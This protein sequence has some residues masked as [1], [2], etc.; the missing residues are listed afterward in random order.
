[1]ASLQVLLDIKAITPASFDR[2]VQQLQAERLDIPNRPSAATELAGRSTSRSTTLRSA[3]SSS[4]TQPARS[5]PPPPPR[6]APGA[7]QVVA[8]ADFKGETGDDLSFREGDVIDVLEDG[9]SL[10]TY[11]NSDAYV[12]NSVDE[13]W[14]M[15]RIGRKEGIFPKSFVEK[16]APRTA[17][18]R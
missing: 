16:K 9:M 1:M 18:R 2:L 3:S 5:A 6:A 17:P 8:I 11:F 14:S 4:F 12:N 13:N 15:G 10:L 7:E